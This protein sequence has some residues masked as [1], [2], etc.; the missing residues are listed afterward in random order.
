[1]CAGSAHGCSIVSHEVHIEDVFSVGRTTFEALFFDEEFNLAVG[2]SQRLGRKLIR[3]DR[4]SDRIVRHVC[5]EP[6][7]D[8]NSPAGQAFGTTRASF[9]EE[10]DYDLRAHRGAWRTIP[11]L[12]PERVSNAGTLEL[13]EVPEGTKRIVRGKVTVKL[14]GFGSLVERAVVAEIVKSYQRTTEFT[15]AWLERSRSA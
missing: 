7:R 6:D 11:N 8:P 9:V 14:F 1:M 12:I 10:L 13:V 2:E 15:R 4:T 3:L 5:F